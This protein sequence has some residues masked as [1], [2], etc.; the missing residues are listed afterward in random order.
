MKVGLERERCRLPTGI[1]LREEVL[2]ELCVQTKE[3]TQKLAA[4]ML[5]A[6]V[7]PDC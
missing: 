6:C 3:N 7:N 2:L 5:N 1:A 4:V